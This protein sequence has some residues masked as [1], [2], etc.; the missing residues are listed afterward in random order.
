M[1]PGDCRLVPRTLINR[2]AHLVQ[3]AVGGTVDPELARKLCAL[4]AEV[5][6]C[7]LDVPTASDDSPPTLRTGHQP[8]SAS[9][10]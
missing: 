5:H 2:L 7:P 8:A 1:S 10:R 4:M 3:V 6:A 9:P